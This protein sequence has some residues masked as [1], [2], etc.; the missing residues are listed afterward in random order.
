MTRPDPDYSL[1][2]EGEPF[3]NL[4]DDNLDPGADIDAQTVPDTFEDLQQDAG[5]EVADPM[6]RAAPTSQPV[7]ARLRHHC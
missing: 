6:R 5:D 7:A 2:P 4:P 1:A 3:E